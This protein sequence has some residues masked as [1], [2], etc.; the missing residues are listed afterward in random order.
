[1][2]IFKDEKSAEF[3]LFSKTASKLSDDFD[4]A[5]TFKA[6]LFEGA[7]KAPAAIIFKDDGKSITFDGKFKAKDLEAWIE[8]KALP[9]LLEL[10]QYAS[11]S[12]FIPQKLQL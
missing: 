1:M 9:I 11:V 4:F 5:H 3:Q 2:G 6:D 7:A 10:D 8:A 12:C